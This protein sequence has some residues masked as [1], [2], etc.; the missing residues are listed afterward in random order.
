MSPIGLQIDRTA[1]PARLTFAEGFNAASWFVDRH[2]REGRGG[3]TA[4]RV[5]TPRGTDPVTYEVLARRVGQAGNA[6]RGL[7]V[8]PGD[9]LLMVVKDAPE[10]FFVF[11]GAIKAGIVPVPV[12]G[13]LTA[14]DVAYMIGDSGARAVVYSPEF[15]TTVVPALARDGGGAQGL[16][17]DRDGG[18]LAE[19]ETAADE[20]EPVPAGPDA[21]AFWLYSSGTT[22]RPKG[23]PHAH[24]DAPVTCEHYAVGVLGLGE[25]DVCFSAAKLFFAYGLGNAMTFP[26]HVG[27]TAV[28][29]ERRPTPAS[30]FET[31]VRCRPTVYFGVPTLFAAQLQLLERGADGGEL[32][33]SSLRLCVSAGEALP[34]GLY[35]RW[36]D[37]TGVEILDGIGSTEALH[38][39]ISNVPGGVTPGATGR[40]VP[41]YEARV[42]REDGTEAAA[43]EAGS[44]EIRG[45]SITPGYWNRPERTAA[46]L[47]DGWLRT[48]DHYVCDADGCYRYQ[49]RGDDMMKVGGIWCSP[50]D[51]E[52]RLS[53]H[54]AVLEAA[55]VGREDENGLV[56]PEAWLVLADGAA[57]GLSGEGGLEEILVRHCQE[58]LPR[59]MYPRWFHVVEELPRTAT[60]KI[61][62]FKLRERAVDV[63]GPHGP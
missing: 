11:W 2:V 59:Y 8:A 56:K 13:L 22:G 47:V 32:D 46:T 62:R 41:G 30:T 15:A 48:G 49:G 37:R 17:L 27:G 1:T 28:L 9:R 14:P 53:D 54:P 60:G 44:L 10:F 25:T 36:L 12:N 29:D 39:F 18:F 50:F 20:L 35:R 51:I 3:R 61:Q 52:A 45:A 38:I 6:L 63:P 55:V 23:V 21:T 58:G 26:L 33:L 42:R 31:M 7:D 40:I 34:A 5:A 4:I 16:V 57:D 43:G 19:L 24:R